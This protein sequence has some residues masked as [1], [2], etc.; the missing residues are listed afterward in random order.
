MIR[1][2]D[3]NVFIHALLQPRRRLKDHEVQI[4]EG[5]KKI[6]ERVME[7][8]GIDHRRSPIRDC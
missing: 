7:G 4:K 8:R 6:L 1:F 2:I 3:S 5:A